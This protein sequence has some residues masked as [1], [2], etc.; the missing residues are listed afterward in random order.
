MGFDGVKQ[1]LFEKDQYEST[2]YRLFPVVVKLFQ[3]WLIDH[4]ASQIRHGK[5]LNK[6]KSET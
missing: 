4:Q 3:H 5:K 1:T 2:V 6:C